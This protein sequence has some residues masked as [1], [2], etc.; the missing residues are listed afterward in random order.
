MLR[1]GYCP[2]KEGHGVNNCKECQFHYDDCDGD[3]DED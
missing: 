3:E 2:K 1:K